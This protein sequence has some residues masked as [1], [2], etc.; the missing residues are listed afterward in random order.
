MTCFY[1]LEKEGGNFFGTKWVYAELIKPVNRGDCEY[2]PVCGNPVTGLRWL[3]PHLIKLSG[4]DP[5]RWG[6]FVWGAGFTLLVSAYF[7]D[8]YESEGLTGIT[9]FSPPVEILRLGAKRAEEMPVQLPIYH[10]IQVPW[11][12]ANQDDNTSGVIHEIPER[13]KCSYCR[14][15]VSQRKQEKIII[16]ETSWN[17][18]DIFVPRGAPVEFMVSY[19]FKRIV[20]IYSLKNVWLIPGEKYA[21]DQQ[22]PGP[23]FVDI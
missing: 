18:Q 8:I 12:G 19:K 10:L 1:I 11:G 5:K 20:E 23:W 21:Y 15:G 4:S 3:P 6:D 7:K 22:Q 17:N 14:V 9:E 16:E 13:V 2:C